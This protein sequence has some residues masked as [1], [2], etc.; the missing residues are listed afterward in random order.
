MSDYATVTMRV[1]KDLKLQA[2][3]LFSKLG[4]DMT[5]AYNMFLVQA[6]R[7]QSI[8]FE[9]SLEEP[10]QTTRGV[11]VDAMAGRNLSKRYSDI[12]ELMRDLDA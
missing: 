1:D 9:I 8:P 2:Q 4:M 7:T 5:T 6:V 12:D 11:I 10:N 3:D